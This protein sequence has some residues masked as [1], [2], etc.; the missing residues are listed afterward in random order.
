MAGSTEGPTELTG[1]F[2]KSKLLLPTLLLLFNTAT[3]GAQ[4]PPSDPLGENLF[5]PELVMQHQQALGLSEEQKTYFKTELRQ[6]QALF[7]EFQWRLQDEMEKMAALVKQDNVDE[8][9][10]LTQ[11]DKILNLERDIK[12]AQIALLI[13]I[14]NRLSPEQQVKLRELRSRPHGR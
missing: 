3:L 9:Q 10:T 13:R 5:P 1:E 11:L 8:S 12:R 2:M 6:A 7:T 14:K 4:Q